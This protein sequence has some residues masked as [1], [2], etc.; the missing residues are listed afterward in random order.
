MLF[1]NESRIQETLEIPKNIAKYVKYWDS[2][3]LKNVD[4]FK[5]SYDKLE[6]DND[7]DGC[8]YLCARYAKDKKVM[9]ILIYLNAIH[10]LEGSLPYELSRYRHEVSNPL[11]N[12][13]MNSKK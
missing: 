9:Q 7:H 4:E 11:Y 1:F 10:T 12:K 2:L 6:D 8:A 5:A 3:P 13:I